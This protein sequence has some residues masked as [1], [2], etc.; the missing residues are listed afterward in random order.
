MTIQHAGE[1]RSNDARRTIAAREPLALRTYTPTQL[2]IAKS[3]G[4]FHWTAD[5]R[6]LYDYTSGV[7][8]AN[9]GHN[10]V[11]WQRRFFGYM[12]WSCVILLPLF[13][14]MSF[15]FFR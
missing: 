1:T 2:A 5:G 9:L 8:V 10:P 15:I 3:A 7:L 12:G 4:V 6:R 13:V 14:A 11:G